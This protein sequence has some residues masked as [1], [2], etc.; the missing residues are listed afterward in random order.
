MSTPSQRNAQKPIRVADGDE[1]D[2]VLAAHDRVLVDFYTKGCSL[3]QA[4]EP[5]LGN[6]AREFNS[7]AGSQT[8]SDDVARAT[9]ITVAMVNP[10]NDIS[11][12]DEW[13]I[14]SAPTLVLVE[15]EASEAPQG[16][17]EAVDYEEIA[18][19]ADGFKG[20]DDIEAFLDEHLD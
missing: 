20:G 9:G 19:L 5:V 13:S 3:C 10:G 17:G 7:Q 8:Q 2:D 15:S 6:V 11:L 14:T 1:L 4:I 18:R 16:D 12:V